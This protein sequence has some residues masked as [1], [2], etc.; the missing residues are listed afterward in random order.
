MV[1]MCAVEASSA[2][3]SSSPPV[4]ASTMPVT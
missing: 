3:G 1:H 2:R 4:T